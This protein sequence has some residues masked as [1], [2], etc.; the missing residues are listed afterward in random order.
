MDLP[1]TRRFFV[2]PAALAGDELRLADKALAHQLARVLRLGPGDRV[3]LLDGLGMACEVELTHLGRDELAGRVLRRELAGGESAVELAV[4]LALMRPERFEWA[5]QKC[6][7]LGVRRLVPVQ[8]ARSLPADR[9]DGRK[10]ERWRRIVR[11][12]AEQACRGLL[13]SLGEPIPFALACAEA[14]T[15]ERAL[16]LWEGEAPHLREALRPPPATIAMLSGPEGGITTDEL[17]A[18]RAHGIL[19]VSLGPRI[20]RAETAPMAAAASIMFA[21]DT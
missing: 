20:L 2:P 3:L 4:Y 7:E 15:A 13:P 14:A 17:S 18:A 6:V 9:A 8:F 11:E 5:L 19:P 16:L 21:L 1:N 10:Q 12:A